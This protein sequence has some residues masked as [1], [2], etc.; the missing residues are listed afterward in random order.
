M[1]QEERT[2]EVLKRINALNDRRKEIHDLLPQLLNELI[3]TCIETAR[4]QESLRTAE[5]P[6]P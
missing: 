4:L 6:E 1:T 3:F 2:I 5:T